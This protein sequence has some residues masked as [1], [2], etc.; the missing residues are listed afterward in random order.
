MGAL[1]SLESFT[2]II[3]ND[4]SEKNMNMA[5]QILYTAMYPTAFLQ[6]I[7][8]PDILLIKLPVKSEL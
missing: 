4:I 2:P 1:L 7:D 6:S 5:K 8:T 3:I